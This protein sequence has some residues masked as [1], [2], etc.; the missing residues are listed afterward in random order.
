MS[1]KHRDPSSEPQEQANNPGERQ[2]QNPDQANNPG[3]DKDQD[4]SS[5]QKEMPGSSDT[6]E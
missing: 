2:K 4:K 5:P 3:W 6:D 1:D